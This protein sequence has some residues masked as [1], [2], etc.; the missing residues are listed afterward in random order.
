[1]ARVNVLSPEFERTSDRDGY[2]WR[3]A[4]IGK[5]LGAAQIGATLYELAAGE[6]TYPYHFHNGI[7][8]WLIVLEGTPVLRDPD[9]EQPLRRG[10]VVCFP[11]GPDGA[12]QVR[13][14]GTVLIVSTGRLPETTMYPDSGKV[15]VKPPGK[16]FRLSDATDY[17]EGE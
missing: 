11:L 13:G 9:G 4:Q 10:D 12:H 2:R 15:G 3:S 6:R 5:A 7:E 14:P 1:V 16:V 8:E 17:W